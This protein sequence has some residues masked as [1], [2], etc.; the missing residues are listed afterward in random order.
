MAERHD[1]MMAFLRGADWGDADIRALAG[2]ASTR[3]YFRV[4]S[5]GRQAMLM[6]QPQHAETPPAPA[7]ATPEERRKLGYNAVARLAGAD[8]ARFVAIAGYLRERGLSAPHIHAADCAAGFVL[9]EDFGE[10][11]YAD[12]LENAGGERAL[13]AAAVEALAVLHARPAP[14]EI[15]PHIPLYAYDE[16]AMLAEIGLLTEWYFPLVLGRTPTVDETAEHRALWQALLSGGNAPA[17]VVHRDYHAQNLLWLAERGGVAR[18][19]MIDFQDAVAGPAA[20][21]LVSLI[22]DARREVPPELAHET[23]LHYIS[24]MQRLGTPTDEDELRRALAIM[25][26]QRNAKIAGIFARLRL[27]DGKARY[28]DYLPRVW[29]YLRRDLEHPALAPLKSWYESVL[30]L[31]AREGRIG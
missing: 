22:E 17:V 13:Y 9:M 15:S 25:A 12:V 2:D 21:D 18:V 30:P 7:L 28:L 26:A 3:R 19:G 11:L 23:I 31:S 27:R 8:C 1:A 16:T 24:T 14:A 29:R 5:K 20:Y 4:F 6:D 10:R